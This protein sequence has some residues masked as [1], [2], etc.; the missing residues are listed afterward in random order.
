M[1]RDY[2]L[3]IDYTRA[4]L[5]GAS[6]LL[7]LRE[8]LKVSIDVG[9]P[10]G[11]QG[12]GCHVHLSCRRKDFYLCFPW[13]TLEIIP[14]THILDPITLELWKNLD[15]PDLSFVASHT[16]TLTHTH[17]NFKFRSEFCSSDP[18][19]A[20]T[21]PRALANDNEFTEW[22]KAFTVTK[23]KN[24]LTLF[25]RIARSYLHT[26][27]ELSYGSKATSLKRELFQYLMPKSYLI[28]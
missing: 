25:N 28:Y 7:S 13:F 11:V 16:R 6:N 17:Q 26:S 12:E 8:A 19:T 9:K 15:H 18:S 14:K 2:F 5:R 22:R 20:I 4:S 27:E 23:A 24:T 10:K 1:S 21:T 3:T